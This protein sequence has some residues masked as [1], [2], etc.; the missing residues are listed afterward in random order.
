[1][2]TDKSNCIIN[3]G[4]KLTSSLKGLGEKGT[5]LRNFGN[6]RFVNK[7]RKNKT[8]TAN[9]YCTLV[10]KVVFLGSTSFLLTSLLEWE[11]TD[12]ARGGSWNKSYST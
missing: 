9:K 4:N 10:H 6:N 5:E 3:T 1:M 11:Y 8:N 7:G 2:Q 12:K